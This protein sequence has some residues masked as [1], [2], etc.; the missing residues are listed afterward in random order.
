MIVTAG[1]LSV[2]L[3]HLDG[4]QVA[5]VTPGC[6]RGEAA[7][8]MMFERHRITRGLVQRGL[9]EADRPKRPLWTTLTDAGREAVAR[10]LGQWADQLAAVRSTDGIRSDLPLPRPHIGRKYPLDRLRVG[11][12]FLFAPPLASGTARSVVQRANDD[13]SPRHFV[14]R[15]ERAGIRCWRVV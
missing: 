7:R 14:T 11:E 10:A 8:Q 2:L 13:L 1:M 4:V 9:L 6:A 3:D 12:S 15:K 5:V